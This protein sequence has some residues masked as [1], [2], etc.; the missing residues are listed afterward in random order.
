MVYTEALVLRGDTTQFSFH[1]IANWTGKCCT[2]TA[3]MGEWEGNWKTKV[4]H[5]VPPLSDCVVLGKLLHLSE[6][7]ALTGWWCQS[8]ECMDVEISL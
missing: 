8:N 4:L 1:E 6:S 2:H 5:L 3:S 7:A